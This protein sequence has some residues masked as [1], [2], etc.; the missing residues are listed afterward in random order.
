MGRCEWFVRSTFSYNVRM[1]MTVPEIRA[2]LQAADA[3][4]FAVLER[5]Y[6][7]DPRKGVHAAVEAARR[8]I[9]A[10]SAERRRVEG[11]FRFEEEL[12]ASRGAALAVGLDEVGRGPLAGPLAVGAVVFA[13]CTP[14]MGLNDSKQVRPERR[15]EI[16]ALVKEAAAAWAIEY[17]EPAEIDRIGMTASLRKAFTA[18][19]TDIEAQGIMP[20]AIL[21]D[22]NPLH[23][24][25]REVN[26][27][28]GDAQCASIA[29]ASIIA[30][31]ARD[32]LMCEKAELY[33]AYGFAENK[34]YA[35]AAH[36]RAIEQHGLCPEHRVSFCGSFMQQTLF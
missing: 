18:A 36:I 8:R 21:L 16:A 14:I 35:S 3:Q 34:G 20:D 9:E 23:F 15:T 5:S 31:V 22:G 12:C 13:D 25:K 4:A 17:I 10:E 33:P 30:K 7:D 11:L 28:K 6:A 24:D 27:V 19:V 26:I 1:A 29:A 32:A 2:A